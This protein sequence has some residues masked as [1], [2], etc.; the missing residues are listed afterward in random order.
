MERMEE[1]A[2]GGVG[3]GLVEDLGHGTGGFERYTGTPRVT[4]VA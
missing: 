3:A 1:E 4:N 2:G